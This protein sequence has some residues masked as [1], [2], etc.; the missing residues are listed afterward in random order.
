MSLI[1]NSQ[2]AKLLSFICQ[3]FFPFIGSISV[4]ESHM[5]QTLLY[6]AG[7]YDSSYV[8]QQT[9]WCTVVCMLKQDA[10]WSATPESSH[11]KAWS[12]GGLH[13]C[14]SGPDGIAGRRCL[15]RRSERCKFLEPPN[16]YRDHALHKRPWRHGGCSTQVLGRVSF[17][18][19]KEFPRSLHVF[20]F[21]TYQAS[22]LLRCVPLKVQL[23]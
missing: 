7:W 4:H 12:Q 11:G 10:D 6:F 19:S 17:R 16:R 3:S 2:P 21:C 5:Y 1:R 14:H 20:F 23:W 15:W 22:H 18:Y 8:N 13:L 9:E